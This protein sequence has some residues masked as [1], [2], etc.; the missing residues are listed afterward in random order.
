[1]RRVLLLAALLLATSAPLARGGFVANVSTG[2]N[3]SGNV[4]TTGGVNDANWTVTQDPTYSPTGIPQTVFPGNVGWFPGGGGNPPWVANDSN[5]DW[6]TR[7]ANTTNNGP[8]PYTFTRTFNLTGYNLAT[9]TLSGEWAIDDTG[10]LALNG[11]TL[12]TLTGQVAYGTLN[13]FSAP[14][15]DFVQGVNTLTITMTSN[16]QLYE[17]V[18]LTGSVTATAVPEPSSLLLGGFG[19]LIL[20]A[21]L[22]WKR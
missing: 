7:N 15:A 11:H 18:R 22:R 13:S 21:R 14:G 16:D 1:M 20:G 9:A 4:I 17:G 5:S 8:A 2:L 19:V 6:I 10:T 12:G 3:A